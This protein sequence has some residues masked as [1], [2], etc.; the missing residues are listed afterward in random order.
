MILVAGNFR[1]EITSTVMWM[2]NHGMKIQCFKTTPYEYKEQVLLDIEQ[3]IPVKEAEDYVIKMADKAREEKEVKEINR[4]INELRK[5][6]WHELLTKFNTISSQY[7]NVNPGG[8]HWLSSGSG[9][10]GAPFSFVVTK[11]YAAVELLISKGSQEENKK[12]FDELF[13]K[14]DAIEDSYGGQLTWERLDHKKSSRITERMFNVDITNRDDWNKIIDFLS[15]AM[16][17]FEKALKEPL[18]KAA[19]HK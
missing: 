16:V 10:S 13:S 18:K 15:Q 9:V 7:K 8:D 5:S 11:S 17:R 1:K 19:N 14:R 6:F 12:I 3:I 4:G 2:L